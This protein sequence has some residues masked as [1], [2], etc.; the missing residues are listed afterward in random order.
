MDQCSIFTNLA[1]SPPIDGWITSLLTPVVAVL[2]LVFTVAV[3]SAQVAILNKQSRISTRQTDIL[4]EQTKILVAQQAQVYAQALARANMAVRILVRFYDM[5]AE[6]ATHVAVGEFQ[7]GGPRLD[8][9]PSVLIVLSEFDITWDDDQV[10]SA[11]AIAYPPYTKNIMGA[12]GAYRA[13]EVINKEAMSNPWPQGTPREIPWDDEATR[14]MK[15][16]MDDALSRLFKHGRKL[17]DINQ[18]LFD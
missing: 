8:F 12:L 17:C 4:E 2:T 7:D 10:I 13:L 11:F 6:R 1:C 18:T 9:D 16:R 15:Q 14:D 5:V 3:G